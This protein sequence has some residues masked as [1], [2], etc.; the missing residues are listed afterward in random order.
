MRTMSSR[1][2]AGRLTE[3]LMVA[4]LRRYVEAVADALGLSPAGVGYEV[5]DT[6]TGYV[7]LA[8]RCPALPN[9]DLMLTWSDT[10][11][12]VL[13]TEPTRPRQAPIVLAR[14]HGDVLP[15]PDVVASF[16]GL[17]LAGWRAR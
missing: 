8:A 17:A 1:S 5:A 15:D 9:R 13:A 10:G 16:V 12:W 6:A 3:A 2:G 11:G 4:D 7:A 14:L